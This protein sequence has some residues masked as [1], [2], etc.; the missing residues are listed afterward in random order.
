[1]HV[2]IRQFFGHIIF[3]M[4]GQQAVRY[5]DAVGTKATIRNDTRSF[6]EQIGRNAAIGNLLRP[7]LVL[8]GK[9]NRNTIGGANDGNVS[10]FL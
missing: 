2:D 10:V 4:L 3:V 7:I 9:G 5:K 1:M 8:H 6:N